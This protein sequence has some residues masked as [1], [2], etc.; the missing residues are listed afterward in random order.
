MGAGGGGG[1]LLPPSPLAFG[2]NTNKE[3]RNIQN[4]NTK[5]TNYFSLINLLY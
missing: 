4:I 5:Y 3:K 1:G 2:K